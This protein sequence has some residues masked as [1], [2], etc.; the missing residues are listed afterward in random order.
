MEKDQSGETV[1]NQDQIYPVNERNQVTQK[2]LICLE[3]QYNSYL[4][5]GLEKN[6]T[7]CIYRH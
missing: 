1:W 3:R 6:K 2:L 4:W 5:K 7:L